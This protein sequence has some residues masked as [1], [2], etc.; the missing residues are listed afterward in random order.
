MRRIS[1]QMANN[2]V[3]YNLRLQESKLNRA[4]NQMGSQQKI[5]NLRDD[6]LAAGHLVRYQSYLGR[7]ERFEHNAQTL[8]DQFSVSEGYVNHSLQ[9]M[10][11]IR[12][13]AVTGANGIYS[14]ED[15]R[16]MASEV[17]EYLEELIQNANA[18]DPDGKSLFAGTADDR[19]A[20]ITE[21]GAVP[22]SADALITSV[23][24]NGNV[25]KNYVE[26]DE[27]AVL[28]ADKNG[29]KLFWAEPQML[30]SVRDASSYQVS[31]DS[32]ISVDEKKISLS[33][34]DNVYAIAAKINDSGAAV[35]AS[36]DPVTNGLNL[37]TTDARQLWI[38]DVSGSVFE[39]LGL[40]QGENA[41]P[42]YNLGSS[43]QV[44]GGSLFDTVMALRDAF[45]SGDA[46]AV[47]GRVLGSIDSA[48]DSLVSNLADIGAK[49][50]RAQQDIARA[51]T[52]ELN[53]TSMIAREGDLDFTKAIT[54]MKM[55]E[56]VQ[57]ATLSTAGRLYDNSLLNY[58]R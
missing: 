55:L 6:P 24:Y 22:G 27:N 48:L 23:K 53:V 21:L 43:V 57:K 49:Y 18:V 47:G 12:E 44:S 19:T 28:A 50:E 16:N 33:A 31:S 45:L 14:R 2:D 38:D 29:G 34:G 1:S 52:N 56:Y 3:Q 11:R 26:T 37:R 15:L 25:N 17:N 54:D 42:P 13:L 46:E 8:S 40:V 35:K 4:N 20:F 39:D 10:Q 7:V 32:V 58:L 36:L 41:R 51:G 9:I 30:L 5:L